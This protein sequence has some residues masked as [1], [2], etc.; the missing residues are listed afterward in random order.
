MVIAG[1]IITV[2]SD[3]RTAAVKGKRIAISSVMWV[4]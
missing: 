4:G 1:V 3:Q 2:T